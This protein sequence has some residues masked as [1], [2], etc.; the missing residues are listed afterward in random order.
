LNRFPECII[1]SVLLV[2]FGLAGA[3]VRSAAFEPTT[4]TS[5]P[6]TGTSA[7][8]TRPTIIQETD[9]KQSYVGSDACFPCHRKQGIR[10]RKRRTQKRSNTC[11]K[12]IAPTRRALNA[13]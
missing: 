6:K 10:G 7:P 5:P 2:V 13:M 12:N 4:A 3:I 1:V 8:K 11:L 9:P